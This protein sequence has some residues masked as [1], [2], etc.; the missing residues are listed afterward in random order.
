MRDTEEVELPGRLSWSSINN[1]KGSVKP[2]TQTT[3]RVS[4]DPE[5][6]WLVLDLVFALFYDLSFYHVYKYIT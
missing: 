6:P 4:L 3:T 2:A 5:I 1:M